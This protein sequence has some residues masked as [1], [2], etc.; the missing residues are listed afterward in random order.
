M[1][2]TKTFY[3]GASISVGVRDLQRATAWY[4]E[5]LKLKLTPFH[6]EDYEALLSFDKDDETGIALCLI[7]P[8][9]EQANVEEH[10]IL[11]TKKIEQAHQEFLS[12]DI[13]VG[14]IQ[15]DSG[16]NRFFEFWDVDGN[17]IEIC[18]EP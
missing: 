15:S 13:K 14:P 12:K 11:F 3:F 1:W 17:K 4:Q 16:G 18:V 2:G 9:E 7:P 10:P 8:G 6:S 5:K